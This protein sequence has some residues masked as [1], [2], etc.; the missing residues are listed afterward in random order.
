MLQLVTEQCSPQRYCNLRGEL[1]GMAQ[2]RLVS[3]TE[4]ECG[5]SIFVPL[6]GSSVC[7]LGT[8]SRNRLRFE[9]EPVGTMRLRLTT[10]VQVI[11]ED[12]PCWGG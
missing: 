10:M 2:S 3:M 11:L 7:T 12:L 5:D 4:I 8:M 6:V 9:L 1:W